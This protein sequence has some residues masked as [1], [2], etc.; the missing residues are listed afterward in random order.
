VFGLNGAG[1]L[2]KG[3]A[4]ALVRPD[5]YLRW[6][7]E[8]SRSLLLSRSPRS[9]Q[10]GEGRVPMQ[11]SGSSPITF[12]R[13]DS[14]SAARCL[15]RSP[16]GLKA[17][18]GTAYGPSTA[19]RPSDSASAPP[20]GRGRGS[21][22]ALDAVERSLDGCECAFEAGVRAKRAAR[23]RGLLADLDL[24]AILDPKG[25]GSG[26]HQRDVRDWDAGYDRAVAQGRR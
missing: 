20:A 26:D 22:H 3:Q 25:P 17:S 16:P 14:N 12:A 21:G 23:L 13:P 1:V 24:Q 15:K 10:Q 5:W 19:A 11:N 7:H 2:D 6:Y 8:P 9:A 4:S 18:A